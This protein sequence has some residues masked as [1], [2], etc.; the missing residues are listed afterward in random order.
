MAEGGGGPGG[1][2]GERSSSC[3]SQLGVD[4]VRRLR[5]GGWRAGPGPRSVRSC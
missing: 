1:G 4:G 3:S 5:S 2:P